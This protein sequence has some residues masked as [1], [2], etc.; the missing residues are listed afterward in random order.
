MKY[1]V[2]KL[3]A[4]K[5]PHQ[6]I[7]VRSWSLNESFTL[8]NFIHDVKMMSLK[9]RNTNLTTIGHFCLDDIVVILSSLHR[10]SESI[11]NY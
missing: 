9:P 4:S 6:V 2:A 1:N 7:N 8:F 11:L 5:R 10:Q 3:F